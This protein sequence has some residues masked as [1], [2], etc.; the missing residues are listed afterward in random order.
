[1]ARPK[2]F[3]L[4]FFIHDANASIN[5]KISALS[6]KHGNDGYA[7]YFRLLESLCQRD[8]LKLDVSDPLILDSIAEQFRC[9]D[10][11][12]LSAILQTCSDLGLL[13]KQ[14]WESERIVLSNGLYGR[15]LDRL[16]DRKKAAIRKQQSLEAKK[17]QSKIEEAEA[18]F[19]P[20]PEF[21]NSRTPELTDPDL[22]EL[23]NTQCDNSS[24]TRE[25]L[26]ITRE[27]SGDERTS[28]QETKLRTGVDTEQHAHP[29]ELCDLKFQNPPWGAIASEEFL[30]Y[31]ATQHL[32][33][34]TNYRR[35]NIKPTVQRAK[36]WL[37]N[38]RFDLKQWNAAIGLWEEFQEQEQS[39]D[40]SEHLQPAE[41]IF[42]Q[43]EPEAPDNDR[44][45]LI[46]RLR[47]RIA[48]QRPTDIQAAIVQARE[49]GIPLEEL[50]L[51][52]S[53]HA[54]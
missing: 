7:V 49:F 48:S 34:T 53:R 51:E 21:Q 41:F 15:Y 26:I 23:Q 25:N 33:A 43:P 42:V 50:G 54:S 5:P 35:G 30:K 22:S 8:G 11:H 32:A 18:K 37:K 13:N 27:N 6:R 4:D 39:R 3:T 29:T 38:A 40:L 28:E 45:A 10:G 1:M 14:L 31:I 36:T 44:E 16:E 9:R 2:K 52:E 20:S 46:A 12:H 47:G 24:F 17:L 19:S